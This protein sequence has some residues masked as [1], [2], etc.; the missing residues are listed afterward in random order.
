VGRNGTSEPTYDRPSSTCSNIY[1]HTIMTTAQWTEESCNSC[2]GV[3]DGVNIG[4]G[5]PGYRN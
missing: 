4:S 2:H 1:C 3:K 5:A